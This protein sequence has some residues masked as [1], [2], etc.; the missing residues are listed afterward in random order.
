MSFKKAISS[1]L[2]G[3]WNG[4]GRL[5]ERWTSGGL[6]RE[7]LALISV[8]VLSSGPSLCQNLMDDGMNSE[9]DN[10]HTDEWIKNW[11]NYGSEDRDLITLRRWCQCSANVTQYH[12]CNFVFSFDPLGNILHQSSIAESIYIQIFY[13]YD[14]LASSHFS[15]KKSYWPQV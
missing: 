10:D 5:Y 4:T 7:W 9:W 12:T 6:W 1:L 11:S 2:G 8:S 3:K 13:I 14:C 15:R